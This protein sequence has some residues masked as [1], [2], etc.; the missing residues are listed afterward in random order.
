[1]GYSSQR[2]APAAFLSPKGKVL[3]DTIL[4]ACEGPEEAVYVDCHK[5]M[6][7]SLMR[8]MIRHRL[9][10]PFKID[11]VSA[12]ISAVAALPAHSNVKG[13]VAD[14]IPLTLSEGFFQDPRFA[15]LGKRGLLSHDEV[16]AI[17]AEVE[18][19][20]IDDYH[21]WRIC[22]AVP[23]GPADMPVDT[24]MPLHANL[25]L[26]NFI[27]FAKGCYVGQELT[28]RTKHRGAV[29]RR[30]A[31]VIAQ[32]SESCLKSV[33]LFNPLPLEATS[34][35]VQLPMEGDLEAKDQSS[36]WKKFGSLH[37][38]AGSAGLCTVRVST[39][40]NNATD[41]TEEIFARPEARCIA[42]GSGDDI[43]VFVRAPPYAFS[44]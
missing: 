33:E 15:S 1:M 25:D 14:S 39:A 37:S 19:G 43:P 36:E 21:K 38:V 12:S 29:R 34:G 42:T 6:S 40:L 4:V 24:L 8:L 13:D 30:M 27:S 5:D 3:C 11:D 26:L 16:S 28:A 44:E 32:P 7:K 9:R 31:S 17:A 22:C 10:E 18:S 23:E 35:N 20:S 2:A 41:F